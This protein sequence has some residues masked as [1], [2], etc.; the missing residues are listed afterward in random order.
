MGSERLRN[1]LLFASKHFPGFVE[2]VLAALIAP[3]SEPL[4]YG[5]AS[6]DG[7]CFGEQDCVPEK[8]I[9]WNVKPVVL[10]QHYPEIRAILPH[11]C[12][13]SVR[14]GVVSWSIIPI[15]RSVV[16]GLNEQS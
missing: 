3:H 8:Q 1:F 12:A 6:C 14:A 13:S 16:R 5:G 7:I 11:R 15:P 9:S 2:I 10:A 4:I